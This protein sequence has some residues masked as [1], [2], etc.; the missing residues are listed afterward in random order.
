M[1]LFA[2]KLT[3][4]ETYF[5]GFSSLT[6]HS[7]DY[8]FLNLLLWKL[9]PQSLTWRKTKP[10][11]PKHIHDRQHNL[12]FLYPLLDHHVKFSALVSLLLE[13]LA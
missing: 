7:T 8:H 12:G 10:H 13:R 11:A 5:G 6:L 9:Q 2:F 4:L 3:K 1:L